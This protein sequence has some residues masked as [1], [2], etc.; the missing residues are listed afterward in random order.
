[1]CM[2][3]KHARGACKMKLTYEVGVLIFFISL[4]GAFSY[5][6]SNPITG[7]AAGTFNAI[8]YLDIANCDQIAGCALDTDS[9]DFSVAVH[10]YKPGP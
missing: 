5:D 7:F 4:A 3:L 9:P 8:G 6:F 10:I 2:L 1:M